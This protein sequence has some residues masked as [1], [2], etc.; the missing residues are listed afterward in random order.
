MLSVDEYE[1]DAGK[2]DQAPNL[3]ANAN[4]TA[5]DDKDGMPDLSYRVAPH[6]LWKSKGTRRMPLEALEKRR[7]S[8][9]NALDRTPSEP[10]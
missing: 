2:S 4:K 6:C 8:C 7:D 1:V 5:D 9:S 3:A 10:D